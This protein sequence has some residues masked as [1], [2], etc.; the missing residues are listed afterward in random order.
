MQRRCH[1][2]ARSLRQVVECSLPKADRLLVKLVRTDHLLTTGSRA[3]VCRENKGRKS[4][5]KRGSARGDS[6][7]RYDVAKRSRLERGGWFRRPGSASPARGTVAAP[8]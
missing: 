4:Y 8:P 6:A 3:H 5:W 1:V 7:S 2:V